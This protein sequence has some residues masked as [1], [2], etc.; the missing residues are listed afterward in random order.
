MNSDSLTWVHKAFTTNLSAGMET[1]E[2]LFNIPINLSNF[3]AKLWRLV[4]NPQ[5]QSIRW[6]SNG[7]GIFIDQKLFEA[8]LL[9]P[10]NKHL[11]ILPDFF[12][13]KN[14]AS[15]VRQLNLYGFK[16][17]TEDHDSG[18]VRDR[19]YH[20]RNPNFKQGQPELLAN[21]LRLTSI[22][23]AKLEAGKEVH[24]R[25]P[26]RLNRLLLSL[27]RESTEVMGNVPG[28]QH[29][30]FRG[31]NT[32]PH[33]HHSNSLQQVK[34]LDRTPIPARTLTSTPWRKDTA[35]ASSNSPANKEYQGSLIHHLSPDC[36]YLGQ[37]SGRAMYMEP[38]LQSMVGPGNYGAFLPHPYVPVYHSCASG[39]LDPD[40][41][42]FH[43]PAV[44]YSHY[45]YY[46][47]FQVNYF[48]PSV[49][50]PARHPSDIEE[51]TKN[52]VNLE[53]VFKI[54]DE[55]QGSP[56]LCRVKVATPEKHLNT[57]STGSLVRLRAIDSSPYNSPVCTTR[58]SF[59][60]VYTQ[61]GG[62][63]MNVLQNVPLDIAITMG[64]PCGEEPGSN[65]GFK[66]EQGESDAVESSQKLL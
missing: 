37:Y 6:D 39:S 50:N 13:T 63:S 45:G 22:N 43:Q 58:S 32:T 66:R 36:H 42:H 40:Y 5:T 62:I 28:H 11:G 17:V 34:K 38:G 19:V 46:P 31:K 26:N 53:M 60:S 1:D 33:Y 49:Q 12:K 41:T 24:S 35:D 54:A 52:D 29:Q 9:S 8:E 47:T 44:S 16:K 23:K 14:F 15:F 10:T 57:S 21:V 3:P 25:P 64:T 48:H 20:Y 30:W 18:S 56:V 61:P 7:E 55:L 51:P 59:T 2:S 27:P 65:R 4:N